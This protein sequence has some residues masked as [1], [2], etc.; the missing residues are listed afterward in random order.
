MLFRSGG[1]VAWPDTLVCVG[2][3]AT[4]LVAV[5]NRLVP[6]D[7]A[8]VHLHRMAHAEVGALAARLL[9]LSPAQRRDLPGLQPKRADVIAAGALILD[10]LMAAGDFDAYTCSESDSLVG[11][12]VCARAA[13]AGEPSPLGADGWLPTLAHVSRCQTL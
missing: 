5:A 13:L 11:L 7:S 4:S 1:D 2:G 3:T 6:Y 8:F 12:L 10:E 9:A